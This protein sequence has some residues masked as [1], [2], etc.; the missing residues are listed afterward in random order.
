MSRLQAASL[1]KPGPGVLHKSLGRASARPTGP[2]AWALD[3][4]NRIHELLQQHRVVGVGGR[5]AGSSGIRLRSTGRWYWSLACRGLSGSGRLGRPPLGAHAQAVEAGAGPVELAVAAEFVQ[6]DVMELLPHP[7]ALPVA[8]AS[9]AGDGAAAA[10]LV[11]GQW[12]PGDAG[13]QLVDDASQAGAVIHPWAGHRSGVAGSAAAAGWSARAARGRGRRWWSWPR[14][15]PL[16]RASSKN[17]L[18]VGNT[19]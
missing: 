9:P 17:R 16:S 6:H 5:Q 14:I 15:M 3:R 7:G 12:P 10:E 2:P 8:Q 11:G 4:R 18:K 19:L 13:T 1:V